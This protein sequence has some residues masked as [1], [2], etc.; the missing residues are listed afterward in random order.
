VS[1]EPI[2]AIWIACWL[3]T[4]L[5]FLPME[6]WA[7]LTVRDQQLN[8]RTLGENG[9]M[10]SLAGWFLWTFRLLGL[11]AFLMLAL[12]VPGLWLPPSEPRSVESLPEWQQT[13]VLVG[14]I[15]G[16]ICL[17]GACGSMLT[18]GLMSLRVWAGLR[19]RAKKGTG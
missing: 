2:E 8:H 7:W 11:A 13:L 5:A 18:L 4:G 9:L 17:F 15:S 6:R 16:V 14:S 10:T 1:V 12:A 19:Q 3:V